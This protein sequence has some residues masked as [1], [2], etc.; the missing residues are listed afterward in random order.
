MWLG[1]FVESLFKCNTAIPQPFFQALKGPKGSRH[2]TRLVAGVACINFHYSLDKGFMHP[3]FWADAWG[4]A[5]MN[6]PKIKDSR[7]RT[8]HRMNDDEIWRD[9]NTTL[10]EHTFRNKKGSNVLFTGWMIAKG[11]GQTNQWYLGKLWID[12]QIGKDSI[13]VYPSVSATHSSPCLHIIDDIADT[14]YYIY[15]YIY[16]MMIDAVW[17]KHGADPLPGEIMRLS[18]KHRPLT[19]ARP[20]PGK[21]KPFLAK[22][23]FGCSSLLVPWMKNMYVDVPI[24]IYIF[25]YTHTCVL[26]FQMCIYL[27][28]LRYHM[29]VYIYICG[30]VFY[31]SCAY[32]M[33][34]YRER[35][36]LPHT[37][38]IYIYIYSCFQI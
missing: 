15:I 9:V 18:G 23:G 24:Y 10:E 27:C 25:K 36:L 35:V 38:Y 26:Y 16:V 1:W 20:I 13:R 21:R 8:V 28:L 32:Y 5:S 29:Y 6:S 34:I 12:W 17:I 37:I 7:F 3:L 22:F 14:T 31:Y 2:Q 4:G 30:C 11:N 19:W 33:Y